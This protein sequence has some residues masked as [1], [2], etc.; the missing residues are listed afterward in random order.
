M[1]SGYDAHLIL[2]AVK[3][4]HGKITVISSNMEHYMS[5]TIKVTITLQCHIHRLMLIYA[6]FP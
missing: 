2:S 5:F 4:H 1:C 3:P 6:L